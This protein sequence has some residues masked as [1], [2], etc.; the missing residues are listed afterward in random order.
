[1]RSIAIASIV[2]L[3]LPNKMAAQQKRTRE[4][5]LLKG[6]TIEV[7]QSYKPEVK[8]LPKPEFIPELPPKDTSRPVFKY[9]VP[10]QTLNYTYSSL[11]LR[12]LALGKD[13]TT[14]PF[15]GY[16]KLGGGNLSTIYFDA[17]M[18]NIK[19]EK[20]ESAIHLHHLSQQGNI[21][22]QKTSLS[23]IAAEGTLHTTTNAWRLSVDGLRNQYHYYGYDHNILELSRDT[24]Q[25]TFTGI[26]VGLDL[27]NDRINQRGINYHPMVSGSIYSDRYDATERTIRFDVPVSKDVDE[28]LT[29][30][31]GI[32][33]VIT[34]LNIGVGNRTNNIFQATPNVRYRRNDFEGK[35]GLYPTGGSYYPFQLLPDIHVSYKIPNSQFIISGGWIA[36]IVQ[37]TYKELTNENPYLFPIQKSPFFTTFNRQTKT[38]EVFGRVQTNLG[39]HMTV[40]AKVSW[41]QYNNLPMFL[42]DTGDRKNFYVRYDDKVNAASLQAGIRYQVANTISIGATGSFYN[43]YN[44][45]EGRVWHVPGVRI[46]GDVS[47]KPI[48]S[49]SINGYAIILDQVYAL[50]IAHQEIR[51]NGVYDVGAGAEYQ[52]VPRL[53]A[54]MNLN[55]ILNDRYQRWYQYEAY[56][57]NVFGGLRLKF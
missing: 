5:T 6:T 21:K 28:Y 40:S 26:V 22:N 15:P 4:D 41:W 34:S 13:T 45:S 8:Q 52:F 50:N 11:P 1:M 14:L 27:K 25:Q 2:L 48:P 32:N 42:N 30:G 37:N 31:I 46:K 19:G 24:V 35:V 3:L 49:L 47:W 43:F 20:Y 39:N 29:A 33:G 7:I 18:G 36:T 56:G 44:S 57:F 16:V 9:D 55:N 53:S 23:G 38:D 54:F 12:P 17:G 10:Q 51:L